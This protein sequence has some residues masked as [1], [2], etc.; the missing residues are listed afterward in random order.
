MK[1]KFKMGDIVVI[2]AVLL[3]AV[4]LFIGIYIP[5]SGKPLCLNAKYNG[6]SEVYSLQEDSEFEIKSN[7]YTLKV[8]I[9]NGSARVISCDCPDNTCVNTG[10][11]SNA[12]QVIACVPARVT[13]TLEGEE[14]GYDFVAG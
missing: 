7:G 14:E 10:S 8:E 6:K 3:L 11:I 13:L 2:S 12:G 4:I 9:K 1:G 5:K